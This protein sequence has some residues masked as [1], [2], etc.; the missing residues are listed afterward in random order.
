MQCEICG[1]E[2]RGKS[3]RIMVDRAELDACEKCKGFGKEVPRRGVAPGALAGVP[4]AYGTQPV[5][6][7]HRSDLFDK[8]KDELVEDYAEKIKNAREARRL[9]DEALAARIGT[10]V[11]ILLKVERGELV[12]EDA[13]V[14]KLERELDIKLTEGVAEAERGQRKGEGRVMT[15]GD[16]I[17]VKKDKR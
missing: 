3:Y 16:L 7:R 2:I 11:N 4:G 1:A 12:P 13:L 5:T 10:K 8:I 17:K 14:K 9:T 6:T 15:L